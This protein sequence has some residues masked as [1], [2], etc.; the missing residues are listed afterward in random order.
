MS[1]ISQRELRNESGRVLREVE[2]GP[3]VHHHSARRP[4]RQ[5]RALGRKRRSP[6]WRHPV[7]PPGPQARTVLGRRAGELADP[8]E[9]GP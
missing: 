5:D 4:H 7:A 6:G 9:P 3:R 8:D 1:K 2:A